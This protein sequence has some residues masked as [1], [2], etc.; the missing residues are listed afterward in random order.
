M[1]RYAGVDLRGWGKVF[2]S[3]DNPPR[4]KFIIFSRKFEGTDGGVVTKSACPDK[5][6][7]DHWKCTDEVP[8][9]Q[10][11]YHTP[12]FLINFRS[13]FEINSD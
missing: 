7:V 1:Y 12:H 4:L 5:E 3:L 2:L 13:N 9:S 11:F 8:S 6:Q 10:K